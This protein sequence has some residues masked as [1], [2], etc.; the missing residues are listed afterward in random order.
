MSTLKSCL[1]VFV[2]LK[3]DIPSWVLNKDKKFIL[4]S[5]ETKNFKIKEPA[6]GKDLLAFIPRQKVG[7]VRASRRGRT[8][9]TSQPCGN[10]LTSV[11]V[12]SAQS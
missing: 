10:G 3:Q 1:G 12:T 7:R 2:L 4:K 11:T 9:V 6:L 8:Y 5:L